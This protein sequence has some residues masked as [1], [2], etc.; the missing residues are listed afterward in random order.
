MG[1]DVSVHSAS[2]WSIGLLVLVV[3]GIGLCLFVFYPFLDAYLRSVPL[4]RT[5]GFLQRVPP[6]VTI[7]SVRAIG[8]L[9]VGAALVMSRAFLDPRMVRIDETGIEVRRL[10]SV[11]RG[12][13]RDFVRMRAV[14]NKGLGTVE[15]RF[16]K[17]PG[18]HTQVKLPPRMFGLD[19]KEVITDI[20]VY[21]MEPK[22]AVEG[23][24]DKYDPKKLAKQAAAASA[25]AEAAEADPGAPAATV[26]RSFGRR[27][28][29][30]G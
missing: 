9:L 18:C 10:W 24:L 4:R 6:E 12:R 13:W 20:S 19:M 14:G 28:G 23:S 27:S 15:M 3:G 22:K 21:V 11:R 8:G 25:A 30:F 1:R 7:W 26:R 5:F 17:A 2:R 16:N 29:T